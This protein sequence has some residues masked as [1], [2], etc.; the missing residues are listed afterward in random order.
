MCRLHETQKGARLS[1]AHSVAARPH[2]QAC[3]HGPRPPSARPAVRGCATAHTCTATIHM[4]EQRCGD[5]SVPSVLSLGQCAA[6]GVGSGRPSARRDVTARLAQTR[7]VPS[8]T[9]H[10]GYRMVAEAGS[11][12]GRESRFRCKSLVAARGFEPRTSSLS[13]RLHG[14]PIQ[15]QG[16][17][18]RHREPQELWRF[19]AKITGPLPKESQRGPSRTEHL[20]CRMIADWGRGDGACK[21]RPPRRST[22]DYGQPS[23]GEMRD[24]ILAQSFSRLWR[25]SSISCASAGEKSLPHCSQT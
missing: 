3:E 23:Q 11:S 9:E 17:R 12:G 22:R 8:T 7:S 24:W 14:L 5:L 21:R 16:D 4:T 19:A 18:V 6:E 25:S 15:T 2:G 1:A 10:L 13:G 20:G